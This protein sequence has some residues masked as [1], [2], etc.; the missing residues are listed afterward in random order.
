MA[1]VAAL[2]LWLF[3]N[4]SIIETRTIQNI[5]IR[6][7]NLPDNKTIQGLQPNGILDNRMT[8]TLSGSKDVMRELEPGDFEI[9]LDVSTAEGDEWR[10]NIT[11]KNLVSFVSSIDLSRHI[12]HVEHSELLIKLSDLIT[13][14]VPITVSVIG[15]NAP[16]GYEY[17]DV[18]P[19]ELTQKISGPAEDVQRLKING[20]ELVLDLSAIS[21]TDLDTQLNAQSIYHD[22]EVTFH[23]PSQW[24]TVAIP[25]HKFA[26]EQINDPNVE[27]LRID[28]L[29][30]Q[31]LPAPANIPVRVF[32]PLQF[33]STINPDL[34]PIKYNE[35]IKE[36]MGIT[37]LDYPLYAR[38]VGR[39]FLDIIRENIEIVILAS[40]KEERENLY[41]N[42]EFHASNQLENT[43]VAYLN[44]QLFESSGGED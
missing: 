23:V 11:K 22:D 26:E 34:Y 28:F 24:K 17:L 37:V 18:W 20:L 43:Y 27:H 14:E 41:W 4:H 42:V 21:Q 13:E 35:F 6:I 1:F 38:N 39:L 25:Y 5:P 30:K 16:E 31:L 32:Y 8:L 10:V 3:V 2:V 36:K 9:L 40:P 15:E 33:L 12:T 7:A 29:K 19:E 44:S